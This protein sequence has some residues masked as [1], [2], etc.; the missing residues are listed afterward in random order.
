MNNLCQYEKKIL[1]KEV[2]SLAMQRRQAVHERLCSAVFLIQF[3]QSARTFTRL[4]RGSNHTHSRQ[5]KFPRDFIM[6]TCKDL[7]M[8]NNFGRL[9]LLKKSV[10]PCATFM[11]Q[12]PQTTNTQTGYKCNAAT[13]ITASS[14]REHEQVIP[15]YCTSVN[16]NLRAAESVFAPR[17]ISLRAAKSDAASISQSRNVRH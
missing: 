11:S 3:F 10:A 17:S 6:I 15:D 16:Y 1:L 5:I 13:C 4:D 7:V 8:I 12:T 9:I 2:N 14:S